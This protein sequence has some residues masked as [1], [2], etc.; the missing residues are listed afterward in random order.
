[1]VYC[2]TKK[3]KP[4]VVRFDH[5]FYRK[6]H[7]ENV[8]KTISKLGV[9]F[10]NFKANQKIVNMMMIESLVRRGDFCWHCHVGVTAYPIKIAIEKKFHY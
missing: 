7:E 10:I 3:L 2:Y 5:G 9:D 8:K 6:N 1:M 4:L